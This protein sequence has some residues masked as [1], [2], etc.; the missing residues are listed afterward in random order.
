MSECCVN[1][2]A[3][4]WDSLL[5]AET[6][7]LVLSSDQR[8]ARSVGEL[9]QLLEATGARRVLVV[10]DRDALLAS[11]RQ[12][13][14][15]A[16]LKAVAA[17]FFESFTP[18][19]RSEDAANAARMAAAHQAD[20]IVAFGGGS[21]LDV[22]KIAALAGSRPDLAE[23]LARGERLDDADP[24]PL[25]AIPTTSGTGSEATHFAA[26]YVEGR[27]VSVA[28]P[29]LRPQAIV[30]DVALHQAMPGNLAAVTG[31]DALAQ[32]MESLWA[33]SSNERSIQYAQAA[34]KLIAKHLEP[35]VLQGTVEHRLGMMIGSHLAGQAINI[36][37]TTAAHA[38]S[39][40]FTQLFGLSHGHAVAL[41]L[42]H[43]AT[44]NAGVCEATCCDHRGPDHVRSHVEDAAALL[45]VKPEGLPGYLRDLLGRLG[46]A[47]TL[48]EAG[49]GSAAL[50][51]LAS[52]VDPVRLGNNPRR[53]TN[54]DLESL[55]VNACG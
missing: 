20:C 8:I 19:P 54:A 26:I 9:P 25:I 35:S 15:Q 42:G 14:F 44:A 31:L 6:L 30:L 12:S 11:G 2:S 32:A 7:G 1:R 53:L 43:V 17:E 28:H 51:E 24:L 38:L 49:V 4:Q 29:Q 34:G 36:S 40:Q 52:Q 23:T 37:R 27:K 21:C 13:A 33:V 50:S 22:A 47:S 10:C 48:R 45:S 39:Y 46:L 55:L 18:N 3:G 41:T 5:S 16:A